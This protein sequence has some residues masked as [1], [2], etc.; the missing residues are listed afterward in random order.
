MIDSN[1]TGENIPLKRQLAIWSIF[2]VTSIAGMAITPILP[3]IKSHFKDIDRTDIDLLTSLPNMI[4]IPFVLLSGN[5]VNI[6]NR[7]Q[8]IR[9]G[10]LIFLASA[11]AYQFANTFLHLLIISVCLGAGIGMVIPMANALPSEFYFGRERQRQLGICAGIADASQVFCLFMT[12]ILYSNFNWK[13]PFLV[14]LI[15]VVP[16]IFLFMI[17]RPSKEPGI[18][19]VH[20]RPHK[21]PFKINQCGFS[22]KMLISLIVQYFFLCYIQYIIPLALPFLMIRNGYDESFAAICIAYFFL[23]QSLVDMTLLPVMKLFGKNLIWLSF[24]MNTAALF[25]LPLFIKS[26]IVIFVAL[27]LAGIT[28]GIIEPSIW[29]KASHIGI[30]SKRVKIYS[31]VMAVSFFTIWVTPFV[32]KGFNLLFND[33]TLKFSFYISGIIGLIIVLVS[34]FFRNDFVWGV[35]PGETL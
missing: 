33:A 12:G 26:G 32:I 11:I 4:I 27:T 15:A 18:G 23:I 25:L 8:L 28:G 16:L 1:T 3:E 20:H 21:Y 30:P 19:K 17:K 6:K 34:L 13:S 35:P 2:L 10:L 9:L 31:Y 29:Y 14:Y 5:I 24:L 7:L 22:V